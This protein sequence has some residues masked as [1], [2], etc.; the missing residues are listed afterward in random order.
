MSA[1]FAINSYTPPQVT[2]LV[3]RAGAYKGR[4][5]PHRV[6]LSS[7]SAG[8][9][10]SFASA[11][12]LMANTSPWLQENAPGVA[13]ILGGFVFP[14]GLVLCLLTGADLCTSTF[15][16]TTVATLHRRLPVVRMLLHWFICF[17]GNLAGALFM[18]AII[19]GYGNVFGTEPYKAEVISNATMRQVTPDW[20]MIFLRAIG[21]DWLVCLG[22]F[23]GMQGRDLASKIVGIWC[24][25]FGFA[26]LGLDHVVANMFFIPMGIWVGHPDITVGLYIWKGIIPAL[27]GNILGGA[28]FCGAYYWYTYLYDQEEILVDGVPYQERRDEESGLHSNSDEGKD[29]DGRNGSILSDLRRLRETRA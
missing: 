20:H 2:E 27:L 21:C 8:C 3:S 10:L 7:V 5:N 25:I 28:L 19:F 12:S 9:L 17:W 14:Y 1:I 6:F 26:S 11:S 29:T 4:M 24:P 15:M 18:V 13:R 22:C 23:F 16:F